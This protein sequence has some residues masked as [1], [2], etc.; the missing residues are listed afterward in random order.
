MS[1]FLNTALGQITNQLA[2]SERN[3]YLEKKFNDAI[4]GKFLMEEYLNLSTD[5]DDYAIYRAKERACAKA[6]MAAKIMVSGINA[7]EL[8]QT[9]GESVQNFSLFFHKYIES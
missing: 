8:A 6:E 9:L 5:A 1:Y 4:V 3:K 7:E 2:E